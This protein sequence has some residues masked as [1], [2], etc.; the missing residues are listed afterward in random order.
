MSSLK[1]YNT[2]QHAQCAAKECSKQGVYCLSI[3]YLGKKGWFCKTCKNILV[4]DGLVVEDAD[5]TKK[6]ME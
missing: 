5:P 4:A 2:G 6:P 3:L 1:Q